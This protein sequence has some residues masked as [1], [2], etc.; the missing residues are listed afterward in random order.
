[1]KLPIQVECP[2]CGSVASVDRDMESSD[3]DALRVVCYS[4]AQ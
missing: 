3:I 2:E 1:M 4:C